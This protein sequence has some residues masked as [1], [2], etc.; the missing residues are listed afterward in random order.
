MLVR[1]IGIVAGGAIVA[2]AAGAAGLGALAQAA[3]G[4]GKVNH[5]CLSLPF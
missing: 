5:V 4:L 2:T 3:A 1:G